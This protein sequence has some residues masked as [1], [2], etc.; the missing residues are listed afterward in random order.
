MKSCKVSKLVDILTAR[1]EN[2]RI[3]AATTTNIP[4]VAEMFTTTRVA[5]AEI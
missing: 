3:L 4:I 1:G 2:L 5:A